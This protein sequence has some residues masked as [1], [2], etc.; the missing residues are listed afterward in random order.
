MKGY[1]FLGLFFCELLCGSESYAL[2]QTDPNQTILPSF[3]L[4][5]LSAI[6]SIPVSP[7]TRVFLI[8]IIN[9]PLL[10]I[11]SLLLLY[12][13]RHLLFAFNRLF[14]TS[15]NYYSE[16]MEVNWPKVTILV[17]AHNEENV[18]ADLLNALLELDYDLTLLQVIIVN[19][20]STDSTAS[21]VESF[22]HQ[23]P[24]LFTHFNRQ[25]GAPGKSAALYDVTPMVKNPILLIFDA[26]YIPGPFLLKQLVVPFFD[27]EVGAIMGRVV[28]G[29][30]A[31]NLLTQL[32]D[33]DRSGGYQV[34]Q[35]A[36]ENLSCIPQYGGTAGG[37]RTQALLE[38]GGWNPKFLADDTEMTFR[39]ILN[40]WSIV[41]QNKSECIELVPE[42]WLVRNNQIRRWAKGHNQ[43][44]FK[45][46]TP[47]LLNRELTYLQLIDGI[48]LLGI[49]LISPLLLAGWVFF[50]LSYLLN[51]VPGSST[52]FGFLIIVSITGLG[53][54]TFFYEITTALYLDSLR[55]IRSN[56]IRL[57]PLMFLNCLVSMVTISRSFLE[58]ITIDIFR[59]SIVWQRTEHTARE[60]DSPK[61]P[62]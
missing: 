3:P 26:D 27:P 15:K 24:N 1:L 31:K 48:L 53:N 54:A 33:L 21:I 47:L 49:Y 4:L 58:Q 35:Q 14:G 62:K 56:R 45:Y 22:V 44:M 39:L 60:T 51:I 17:P 32:I 43:V 7:Q 37:V 46:L 11:N 6:P 9:V 18:I 25:T 38:V 41:Y 36:R 28:P 19:D 12:C 20:R 23:Y 55:N 2:T 34:N 13:L 57:V 10:I 61:K 50:L 8:L 30:A 16:I 5:N 52:I 40:D 59:K 29:N 42:T